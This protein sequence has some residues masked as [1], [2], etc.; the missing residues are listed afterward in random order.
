MIFVGE[1]AVPYHD[2]LKLEDFPEDILKK[3]RIDVLK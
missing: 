2:A 3:L 1:I